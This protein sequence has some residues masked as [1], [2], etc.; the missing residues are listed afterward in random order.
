MSA[1]VILINI[2]EL[3]SSIGLSVVP[4]RF[5][6][7]Y[8]VRK[9]KIPFIVISV[10][11]VAADIFLGFTSDNVNDFADNTESIAILFSIIMPYIIL[12]PKKKLTFALFVIAMSAVTDYIEFMIVLM[13]GNLPYIYEQ[14][15]YCV[16][17]TV[18]IAVFMLI[19]K[20]S[21]SIAYDNLLE[22]F[23]P[24]VFITIF[25]AGFSVYYETFAEDFPA[26]FS[27]QAARVLNIISVPLILGSLFY[28]ISRYTSVYVNQRE[29]EMQHSLEIK[30]FEDIMQKNQ[31]IRTFRHDYK[32]NLFSINMLIKNGR[33]ND[34]EE[35]IK[36]LNND[37]ELTKNRFNSGNYMIDAI[38]S[39][40]AEKCEKD[41]IEIEFDGR[42]CDK[43]IDNNTIC[44][45]FSNAVDNAVRACT[46]IA[47]CKIKIT[48]EL[49]TNGITIRFRNPVKEKVIIKNNS[50]KTTKSDKVNHGLGISNIRKAAQK[51]NGYA[52]V[53]CDDKEFTL[54]IGLIFNVS[55]D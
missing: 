55:F 19:Y 53:K 4:L 30:H 31:D 46:E 21:S 43:E 25:F 50:V 22:S 40:K 54:E 14:I 2:I 5:L 49:K 7:G 26:V 35:F 36:N 39:E 23:N 28:I 6:F 38:L 24:A 52:D 9:N 27:A 41:G 44:T 42:A 17:N 15:F 8:P 45:I 47:P 48:S 32:N 34:A 12:K 3:V 51:Y 10:L 16:E 1:A 29:S 18:L 37:L 20:R 11:L 33:Y 13:V